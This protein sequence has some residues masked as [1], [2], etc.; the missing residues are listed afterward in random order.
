MAVLWVRK[1]LILTHRYLGIVLSVFFVVWFVSGI[2]M[3]YTGGMPSL[4]PKG[5]LERLAPIDFSAIK[6]TPSDQGENVTLLTVMGR[7]AYRIDGQTI[8]ADNGDTLD[9]VD[10]H[11]ALLLAAE[12]MKVPQEKV[13]YLE[14]LMQADQWT[15]EQRGQLPLH[16]IAIDDPD[17]TQIYISP[18]DGDVALI[19][20]RRSRTLAWIAAI[21]HW[22]Y[23]RSLR[24]KDGAWRALIIGASGMG[25]ILAVIGLLVGIVQ[26]RRSSPHIPYA[27]WMRWHY[28][29]GAFFGVITFTWVFSGMLSMEPYDVFAQIGFS[30]SGDPFA[31]PLDMATFPPF[32]VGA[33][34][35]LLAGRDVKE[36]EFTRMQDEPYYVVRTVPE[37]LIVDARKFQIRREAFSKESLERRI[38][39]V[40]PNDVPIVES[41]MLTDYDSYY[42]SRDREAPLPVLRVKF[43]D[44]EK[45]WLYVDPQTSQIVTGMARINRIKRWIYTGFHD[46]D[47]S[48]W[49]YRRP[50]WDIGLI[51][52]SLGGLTSSLI[53]LCIGFKR[54]FRGIRRIVSQA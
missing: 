33:M 10:R 31:A 50:L 35:R 28:L 48:F 51:T 30:L 41:Q 47:F 25:I 29:T 40:T 46:L 1:F 39:S 8:F 11:K 27:R 23:F 54:L 12:Y 17:Q 6:L 2:G 32:D 15:I 38:A 4:T 34:N 43:G 42:Y 14:L 36:I 44:P 19:T 26:F 21:P 49:F 53:G 13:R 16:K 52:L 7:P 45:T 37:R 18:S 20:T 24:V 9:E 5:R 22:L 3:M